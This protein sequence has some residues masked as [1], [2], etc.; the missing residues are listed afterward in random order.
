MKLIITL[1]KVLHTL[2]VRHEAKER[3]KQLRIKKAAA[4]K[5]EVLRQEAKRAHAKAHALDSQAAQCSAVAIMG[6]NDVSRSIG[7]AAALR[8][9]L[10]FITSGKVAE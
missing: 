1:L 2:S 10:T 4:A 8:S 3:A 9:H 7:E 5:E 6:D